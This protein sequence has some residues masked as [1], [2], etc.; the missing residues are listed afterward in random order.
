MAKQNEASELAKAYKAPSVKSAID[1]L[2]KN[3]S[4]LDLRV[5]TAFDKDQLVDRLQEAAKADGAGNIDDAIEKLRD[6]A[7]TYQTMYLHSI[8][9][10]GD[11]KV[12]SMKPGSDRTKKAVEAGS[13]YL[14][15]FYSVQGAKEIITKIGPNYNMAAA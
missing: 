14:R 15:G 10:A 1:D 12:A 5:A 9:I 2:V 7:N 6:V 3:V 13:N 11:S 8:G 4:G